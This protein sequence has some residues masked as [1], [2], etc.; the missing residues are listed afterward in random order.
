MAKRRRDENGWQQRF[1]NIQERIRYLHENTI[2]SDF[3][4]ISDGV[5]IPVHKFVLG[6]SSSVFYSM[7]YGPMSEK[8]SELDLSRYGNPVCVAKFL[9]Y[10]YTNEVLLEWE[11]V[12]PILNLAK[13]YLISGL[14]DK[15]NDFM[16]E[17]I[18]KENVLDVLPQCL[19][20][21]ETSVLTKFLEVIS[22][23]ASEIIQQ[24]SFLALNL[25]SLNAILKLDTLNV[26]E[27]DLFMAVNRWCESQLSKDEKE[28]C[29]E[30]KRE[31]LGDAINLIRFPIMSSKEF[32][33]NCV[34]SGLLKPEETNN[35]I[36]YLNEDS[37]D[38]KEVLL[39]KTPFISE[40]RRKQRKKICI[41]RI[42]PDDEFIEWTDYVM[43][44]LQFTLSDKA[45]MT[46]LSLF[47]NPEYNKIGAIHL[48]TASRQERAVNCSFR[49]GKPNSG[50]LYGTFH[51]ALKEPYEVFPNEEVNIWI[52]IH[53]PPVRGFEDNAIDEV[54][55]DGLSCEF[56]RYLGPDVGYDTSE[57]FPALYFELDNV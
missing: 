42:P 55:R 14:E 43:H 22:S 47:G 31:V 50:P 57:Q 7:F 11:D 17:S 25:Q 1:S 37:K 38:E 30:S 6:S 15:C 4:L 20:F 40:S 29:P 54:E 44:D 32:S 56:Y 46:G 48:K 53:G 9:R 18:T 3:T 10:I 39:R 2:M 16:D 13:C 28:V 51:V 23:N 52:T 33:D 5:R 8:G 49:V 41:D 19:I 36:H 26:E 34:L 27:I 24:D 12:F 21:G 45:I 35:L